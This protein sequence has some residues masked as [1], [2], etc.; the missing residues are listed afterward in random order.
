[1]G[2]QAAVHFAGQV[3]LPQAPPFREHEQPQALPQ[4]S[5]PLQLMKPHEILQSPLPQTR[6][7]T[8]FVP[9]EQSKLQSLALSPRIFPPQLRWPHLTVQVPVPQR[10]SLLQ[11][12]PAEQSMATFFALDA[13]IVCV[14]A[15]WP[16]FT[17][18][19][20]LP[21]RITSLQVTPTEQSMAQLVALLQSIGPAHEV[22]P[23]LIA[24]GT[25]AGQVQ[26][27]PLQVSLQTPPGH[28]PQSG[29]QTKASGAGPSTVA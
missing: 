21:Q 17:W 15:R 27:P 20:P 26:A 12:V 9:A 13:L 24:Q 2:P 25:P 11:L 6:S 22:A 14:Q 16:H 29:G 19:S 28:P 10:M 23:Q 18:Q 8:Q 3:T 4:S 1:M 5:A 7:P